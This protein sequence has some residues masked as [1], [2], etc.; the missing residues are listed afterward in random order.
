[1][2]LL[3]IL[4]AAAA[5]HVASADEWTPAYPPPTSA[6]SSG[7]TMSIGPV[8]F[9]CSQEDPE[10]TV[11]RAYEWVALSSNS[12]MDGGMGLPIAY[13]TVAQ[14]ASPY[15]DSC[16]PKGRLV[17]SM[18]G[19]VTV[20]D[21][22]EL[23]LRTNCVDG[24][25]SENFTQCVSSARDATYTLNLW[26]GDALASS[27]LPLPDHKW[28]LSYEFGFPAGLGCFNK[29][30]TAPGVYAGLFSGI[31]QNYVD[32]TRQ[33]EENGECVGGT[34][35]IRGAHKQPFWNW[36]FVSSIVEMTRSVSFF[37]TDPV[38][39]K[40]KLDVVCPEALKSDKSVFATV[41]Y[42]NPSGFF[43]RKTYEMTA[44]QDKNNKDKVQ[45]SVTFD[46]SA[47][48][49]GGNLTLHF[50]MPD[51][52]NA[53]TCY[54]SKH[55][56]SPASPPAK[57]GSKTTAIVLG[58]VFGGLAVVGVAVAIL[59]RSKRRAANTF[60]TSEPSKYGALE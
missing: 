28:N 12:L 24:Q 1:M 27:R 32:C 17:V 37:F 55:A 38:D 57:K 50:L 14:V 41:M 9:N 22:I 45:Y 3:S 29:N 54:L 13:M 53:F 26:T 30:V 34:S 31:V 4:L 35:S 6:F 39:A 2:H 16:V 56:E 25:G 49:S 33:L 40:T 60:S 18:D 44:M 5:S 58:C 11:D 7:G 42:Q 21:P 59:M 43:D 23:P 52:V 47:A 19:N 20:G 10:P 46:G 15:S 48:F 8:T 51:E 36:F